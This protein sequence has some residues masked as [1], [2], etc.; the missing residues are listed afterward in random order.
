MSLTSFHKFAAGLLGAVALISPASAQDIPA[1][2]PAGVTEVQV[3]PRSVPMDPAAV[4]MNESSPLP[5]LPDNPI[6]LEPTSPSEEQ[7]TITPSAPEPLPVPV[8]TAIPMA[9][10]PRPK[11]MGPVYYFAPGPNNSPWNQLPPPPMHVPNSPFVEDL[12]VAGDHG[13]YPYYSY[14]RPWYTPG[15]MNANVTIIW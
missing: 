15:Q 12:S 5:T 14:R 4:P 10:G 8:Q 9:S 1:P 3:R 7:P 6:Q 2:P 13:R 11:V